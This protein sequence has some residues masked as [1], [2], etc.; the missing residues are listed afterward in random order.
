[1]FEKRAMMF[2]CEDPRPSI[3]V[4]QV[5]TTNHVEASKKKINLNIIYARNRNN[6][7]SY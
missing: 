4:G 2:R 5:G 7:N 3:F 1:M 6:Q